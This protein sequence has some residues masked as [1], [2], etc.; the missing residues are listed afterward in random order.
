L[1]LIGRWNETSSTGLAGHVN[2][3]ETKELYTDV[4]DYPSLGSDAVKIYEGYSESNI[5][6]FILGK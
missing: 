5:R 2:L 4:A 6:L 1:T 3:M